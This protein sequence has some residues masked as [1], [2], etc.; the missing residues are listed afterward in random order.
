MS[1]ASL[2]LLI[3]LVACGVACGN[4]PLSRPAPAP[5]VHGVADAPVQA[6]ALDADVSRML[7]DWHDAA[8]R[9]D[10]ARYFG[11]FAEGGVFLGTDGNERWTV[12]QFQAYAHPHFA[13]GKAWTFHA[14]RRDIHFHLVPGTGSGQDGVAWFDEDLDTPHLGPARGSGVLVRDAH[15][16]WKIAQYNLSIP[17][18]NERFKEVRAAIEAGAVPATKPA[19]P[20]PAAAATTPSKPPAAAPPGKPA[21]KAEPEACAIARTAR[22]H[23]KPAPSYEHICLSEGGKL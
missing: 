7:D 17:I 10:E 21:P 20:A 15:G 4:A 16:V 13:K 8:A 19:E 12:P 11:H 9:A 18:P 22:A 1:R 3:S 2:A 5:P 14:T 23:G 6:L